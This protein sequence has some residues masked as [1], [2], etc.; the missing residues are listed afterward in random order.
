MVPFFFFFFSHN[1]GRCPYGFI[2]LLESAWKNE[3]FCVSNF[4]EV[5]G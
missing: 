3:V 4:L 5:F 1:I 2:V